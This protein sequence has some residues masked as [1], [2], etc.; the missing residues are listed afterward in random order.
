MQLKSRRKFL[1]NASI[2]ALSVGLLACSEESSSNSKDDPSDE[3]DTA[4]RLPQIGLQLWSVREDI[5]K[6]LEGTLERIAA[7]GFAGIET[8]FW[9]E[10]VS[11]DA[12]A[13]A[14]EKAGLSVC[15]IH[16][17]IPVK[18]E[19]SKFLE[20]AEAYQ[21]KNMIW[22]GWPEDP[23]YKT[24]AGTKEL[25]QIYRE[26]SDFSQENGLRFGLHNHWWEFQKMEDADIMPFEYLL[27]ELGDKIFFEIDCYWAS[28][29]KQNPAEVLRKWG[30]HAEFLHIKDGPA[31]HDEPMTA[32]GKGIID[33]KAVAAAG[34]GSTQWM[35]VELDECATDMFEAIEQSK[36]YLLD[37]GL[38]RV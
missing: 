8:A 37:N 33:Y 17:E 24:L 29:A 27:T 23:R 3:G 38:A 10:G 28:V 36:S 4:T 1:R 6:D 15:S 11:L 9:P 20:M 12:G 26:A 13:K 25:A 19:Q 18:E 2:G 22:H 7:I 31:V 30:K 32:V 21:C 5:E 14:L 34:S 16:C 35:V